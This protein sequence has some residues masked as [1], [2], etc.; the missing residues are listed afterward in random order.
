[1]KVFQSDLKMVK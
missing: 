1:M